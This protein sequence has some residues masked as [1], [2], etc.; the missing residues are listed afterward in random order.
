[1]LAAV[2]GLAGCSSTISATNP[3]PAPAPTPLPIAIQRDDAQSAIVV[4]E[5]LHAASLLDAVVGA[6]IGGAG[7]GSLRG[8]ATCKNGVETTVVVS[9]NMLTITIKTFYDLKCTT[10]HGVAVL[11][12]TELS[13]TKLTIAGTTT[14]YDTNGKAVAYGTLANK[15]T[16]LEPGARTITTGTIS[17]KL[18][19]PGLS[20]G[21]KCT[22]L[23]TADCGFGGVAP[24][25]SSQAIGFTSTLSGFT[26]TGHV[27]NGPVTIATYEGT[28]GSLKLLPAFGDA[29]KI[30]GGTPVTALGGTF[31]E[32]VDPATLEV[33]GNLRLVDN[34]NA[35]RV[36]LDFG[37][38][39][40]LQ[41]GRVTGS[42]TG[43]EYASFS[44]DATGTGAIAYSSGPGGRII[45]FVIQS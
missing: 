36:T 44:T 3:A 33:D 25:S 38:R 13:S 16:L 43:T 14:L 18:G 12:V 40:G 15:T 34:T 41:N 7:S 31:N 20:F 32:S 37:T 39:T 6:I 45:L 8:S 42:A 23:Q 30:V 9:G 1:M 29:W 5:G 10:R 35:A 17:Q 28:P 4:A 19:G 2:V 24:L 21:L 11:N 26:G 27:K 22:L